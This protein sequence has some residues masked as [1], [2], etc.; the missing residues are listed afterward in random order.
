[1]FKSLGLGGICFPPRASDLSRQL[2]HDQSPSAKSLE[3]WLPPPFILQH[4]SLLW[5]P[6]VSASRLSPGTYDGAPSAP[7]LAAFQNPCYGSA[8][9]DAESSS[10]LRALPAQSWILT[11]DPVIGGSRPGVVS[12]MAFQPPAKGV[13][14]KLPTTLLLDSGRSQGWKAFGKLERLSLAFLYH[15]CLILF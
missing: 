13:A 7:G 9:G 15:S 11:D 8:A 5:E 4:P 3:T 10:S 2:S 1:M 12:M 6:G 14:K